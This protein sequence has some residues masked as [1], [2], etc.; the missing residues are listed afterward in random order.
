MSLETI[1]E[2]DAA[3]A[4]TIVDALAIE[5]I[6]DNLAGGMV[7]YNSVLTQYKAGESEAEYDIIK[8]IKDEYDISYV[9][10]L[11]WWDASSVLAGKI[12]SVELV[13]AEG[14]SNYYNKIRV[15]FTP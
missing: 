8:G 12:D 3:R 11:A 9:D 5:A 15:N 2:L 13:E 6:T 4:L 10:E 7:S 14:F 1:E